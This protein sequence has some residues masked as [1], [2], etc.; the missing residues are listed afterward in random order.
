MGNT[1][2]I[3]LSII[4]PCYNEEANLKRGVLEEVRTYLRKKKFSWEVVISDDG[5]ND[6]SRELIKKVIRNWDNFRLLENPHGGKP[7]ALWYGIKKAKG[8]YVLFTDMDQSTPISELD[9]LLHFIKQDY[10]VVI[11]SRGIKRKNFPFYRRLGAVVFMSLRKLLIL[12]NVNDTQ[13]GFK[14]L[15]KKLV[16]SA[17]PKL[18]YFNR[19]Q[20]VKGWKVTSYDVE[21]LHIIKKMGKKIAEVT[22]IWNDEDMSTTKGGKLQRYINESKEM[23][24]QILRVKL[25]D[26]MGLY[27]S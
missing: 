1:K 16:L 4:I 10:K 25:N 2:K 27:D 23:F 7:S 6:K 11:G 26:V 18:E 14:L 19:K 22:V 12:P 15:N 17:F 24:R 5:S 9:K 20:K 3:F 21:L 8:E 13:C